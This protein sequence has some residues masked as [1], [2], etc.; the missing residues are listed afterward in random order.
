MDTPPIFPGFAGQAITAIQIMVVATSFSNES[1]PKTRTQYS[2]FS[3][4]AEKS[5]TWPS[6]LAMMVIYT[7]AFVAS[8]SILALGM[9][10]IDCPGTPVIPQPSLAACLCTVHF[11]KRCLEVL[12]LHKYSGRTDRGTPTTI[13]V[14]YTLVAVLIAYAAGRADLDHEAAMTHMI[15]GTAI[16]SVGI[17]GNFYHHYLLAKLRD[18][19][20]E[21]NEN[22]KYVA[23][24]GGL[25]SFVACPH[26]LFELLGWLGIAI[27]SHHLN[28][29]LLCAGMTSYLAGRSVAQNDF[30][31][32]KFNS[33]EWPE[34]R[35]NLV[36]FIF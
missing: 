1:N 27:A 16:F 11:L 4:V 15:V 31:R 2:K 13:S 19:T 29:F 33:E 35:K 18:V 22:K 25:F 17:A 10:G 8:T 32:R 24:K 34:D 28:V 5:S 3:Q 21:N 7:P 23:P 30:N 20:K 6:R 26:Y 9:L 36:P 12:L 14:Y